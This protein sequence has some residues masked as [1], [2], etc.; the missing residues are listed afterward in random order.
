MRGLPE[1]GEA[2]IP[3]AW[4]AG[5]LAMVPG[6]RGR[7]DLLALL[8]Q[9][10][11]GERCLSENPGSGFWP[12]MWG[13]YSDGMVIF[14]SHTHA[15]KPVV[16][17][18]AMRLAAIFGQEAV[19]YDSWS[20]KPGDG[21]IQQMNRGLAAPEF[22]FFFVSAASLKSKMVELEWQNALYQSTQG[23][24]RIVPVRVD[25]T[26]MPP[27]L[28]QNLYLD[29]FANGIEA[30][31]QQMVNLVQGL[32]TF[33]P[34]HVGFSNLTF[35]V[36]SRS[37]SQL[38][39]CVAA[40]HLLEPDPAVLV[41]TQ[42]ADEEELA[43]TIGTGEPCRMG[44][45]PGLALTDGRTVNARFVA[46]LGGAISPGKP[47]RLK[48]SNPKG[49]AVSFLGVMHRISEHEWATIPPKP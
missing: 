27:L 48:V 39:I 11:T 21:I 44:W 43:V 25:G 13:G 8:I 9:R 31:I 47:L 38:E 29:M 37:V 40:S 35:Q 20:I 28:L 32:S 18:V 26:P 7:G 45:N 23:R 16:E 30:V 46:P 19:F 33:T 4:Q 17:P 6:L 1:Q 10:D 49:G 24:T 41:L 5:I 22:V 12:V 42:A 36:T 14:L 2:V 34:Q 15:D 3:E